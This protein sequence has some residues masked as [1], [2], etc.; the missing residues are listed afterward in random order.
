M[1]EVNHIVLKINYESSSFP[2]IYPLWG[3]LE[4]MI[5]GAFG[6]T[7]LRDFNL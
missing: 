3:A 2:Q 1:G 4:T 7:Y 5:N 6:E